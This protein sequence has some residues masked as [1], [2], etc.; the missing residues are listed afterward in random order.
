MWRNAEVND[1]VEWLRDWN[2]RLPG[3]DARR[4]AG[5][6]GLDLYS[7]FTS[8]EA[9]LR[10]LD[11][12]DPETAALAR[13]RYACLTPWERD[14]ATYGL[15]ALSDRYRSC[16][17]PVT[18]MLG[19]MLARRLHY[20]A[21]D[22]DRFLDAAQNA[23]LVANAERYYRVMYSGHVESWNLR[24]RHMF[25]TLETLLSFHGPESK[26][27]VWEHNSHIGNA[28]ATE[29]GARGE[30]NVG[31]LARER[32]GAGAYLLGFGTDHGTVA[33]AHAWNGPMEVMRVRPSHEESYERLFHESGVP[34]LL[35]PLGRGGRRAVR[36]AL[37]PPRL[38][39]AIGVVY[40]PQTE[41][42]SHYFHA[43]LPRQFDEYVWFDETRAVRPVTEEEAH[44]LPRAHPFALGT[45]T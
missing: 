15:A 41:L 1:F 3:G 12:V 34:S 2:T 20:A 36:E 29:L 30:F 40:R 23:R 6:Y 19:D 5:F 31:Q 4:K 43:I 18:R 14:P 17:E 26:A 7:L 33:A 42:Q 21:E 25:E 38:E 8:I 28:A 22:G 32:F 45:R 9:V 44:R 27:V 37:R 16:E 39:R 10:Y 24:D 35:L 11:D 13:R